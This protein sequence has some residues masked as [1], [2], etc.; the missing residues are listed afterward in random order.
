MPYTDAANLTALETDLGTRFQPP[1]QKGSRAFCA[2]RGTHSA[3]G[4]FGETRN[5]PHVTCIGTGIAPQLPYIWAAAN[6]AIGSF[7]LITDPARP[8]Q[9]L[10]LPSILPP[11]IADRN[12]INER[13]QLLYDGIA[14][15]TVTSDNRVLIERQITMYQENDS[16]VPDASYLDINTPE[17]L[18]RIRFAKIALISTK[19]PRHKLREDGEFANIPVG[20]AIATPSIIRAE[21][22][23]IYRSQMNLGWVEDIEHYK[24]T[25]VVQID[26]DDRNR[27]NVADQPNLVNQFRILANKNQFIV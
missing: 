8:L 27:V 26:S 17:T 1:V 25:L 19:Y 14:T 16:S 11:A 20:A 10:Q 24:T 15:F 5:S 23:S 4:T 9:R 7:N 12:D 3:T 6:A 21:L 13:N 2:Y 18:E 22:L